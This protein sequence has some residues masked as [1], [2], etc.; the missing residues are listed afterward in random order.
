MLDCGSS[1]VGLSP[2]SDLVHILSYKTVTL[3]VVYASFSGTIRV[4]INCP[5]S[6]SG[7]AERLGGGL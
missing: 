2:V 7:E 3:T 4:G 1:D 5:R 6:I